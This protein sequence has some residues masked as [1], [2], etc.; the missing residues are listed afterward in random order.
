M[1][2]LLPEQSG[3][4]TF[5]PP[6]VGSSSLLPSLTVRVTV[7]AIISRLLAEVGV[8]S[9]GAFSPVAR[10]Q[11]YLVALHEVI[12]QGNHGRGARGETRAARLQGQ[13]LCSP[14]AHTC[15]E[16]PLGLLASPLPHW[17]AWFLTIE[18]CLLVD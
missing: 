14:A 1:S 5:S 9:L 3:L 17:T 13:C 2:D 4:P 10:P 12:T 16:N 7:P 8:R 15:T 18:K 6:R 11:N